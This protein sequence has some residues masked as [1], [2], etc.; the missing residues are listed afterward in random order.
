MPAEI[1]ERRVFLDD[2]PSPAKK[3]PQVGKESASARRAAA[4]ESRQEVEDSHRAVPLALG[5]TGDVNAETAA[6]AA[7]PQAS[8]EGAA[9][10]PTRA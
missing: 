8:A 4:E 6:I 2:G 9:G 5:G 3:A 1:V 10:P 7:S